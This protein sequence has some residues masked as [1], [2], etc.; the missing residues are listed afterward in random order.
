M[1]Q[2]IQTASY[3]QH[4][5]ESHTV[6]KIT[7]LWALNESA[8]GGVL[9]I[10]RI[11]F[12]G[13]IVGS[14]SV[15]LITLIACFSDKRGIILRSTILVLIVKGMVS[16]HTPVNAH[17][18]V[19]L[20]GVLGEFFF[21]LFKIRLAA[22]LLGFSAL[23]LSGLQ[24][25]LFTTIVFGMSVWKSIDLFGNYVISLIPFISNPE[26][27]LPIS[28][29]LI[30]L[31]LLLHTGAGITVGLKAPL[32]YS[33]LNADPALSF[34]GFPAYS[35]KNNEP[36]IPIRKH[37]GFF[38]RLSGQ[39]LFII[40]GIIIVLSYVFPVF[41]KSQGAEAAFMIIRSVF[42]MLIWFYA[43]GPFLMKL[44]NKYLNRKKN[45]YVLE[46][47][48]IIETLPSMKK[49]IRQSWQTSAGFKGLGRLNKFLFYLMVNLLA[50]PIRVTEEKQHIIT[51]QT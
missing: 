42:I 22:F 29:S 13:L 30:A 40:A 9:H 28:L 6:Q 39:V 26:P 21:G 34:S 32:L 31:Y 37:K 18:A 11:P 5:F 12:T 15:L 35:L 2:G 7:A 33:K 24:K 47:Q 51:E 41:E 45:T 36:D 50:T 1:K 14:V 10:F 17:V 3:P 43:A 49:I 23:L 48:N 38:R 19:F 8:L 25:I 46:I 44:M 20:Q 27:A 4:F 16:P